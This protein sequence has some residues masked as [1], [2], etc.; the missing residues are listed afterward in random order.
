MNVLHVTTDLSETDTLRR[1]FNTIDPDLRLECAATVG[2][3]IERL[4]SGTNH[5]DAVLLEL[6]QTNGE[7][8]SLV[9]HIREH[10]FPLGVVAVTS[11]RDEAP[12]REILESGVDHIVVKGK[13]FLP[14]LSIFLARAVADRTLEARLRV[15]LET[16][17]VCLMRVAGDGTILA[18]NIAAL[19]MVEAER[20]EQVVDESWYERVVPDAQAA[21]RDLIERASTGER[22]SLECQIKRLSGTERTVLIGAVR[23]PMDANGAPS[24][25]VV[26]RD[27]DKTRDLET[28]LEQS[29][30]ELGALEGA[31]KAAE[32]KSEQLSADHEAARADWEAQLTA[33]KAQ[34]AAVEELHAEREKLETAL[35]AAET[36][37]QQ[38]SADHEAERSGWREQLAV[39]KAQR[40]AA[41]EEL[42]AEREKLETALKAAQAQAQELAA[43]HEAERT[44]W[45]KQRTAEQAQEEEAAEMLSAERARLEGAL[46]KAKTERQQLTDALASER[47][48]REQFEAGGHSLESVASFMRDVGVDLETVV[49]K[50]ATRSAEVL[51][52]LPTQDP[53]SPDGVSGADAG[54]GAKG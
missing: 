23:A 14:R 49:S 25:L 21:C 51:D 39:G 31:L 15:M 17:P 42:S 11:V 24:A 50:I 38:L 48:L 46:K 5:H 29:R 45:Q 34:D 2:E 33:G 54:K 30:R 43:E 47:E 20:A 4:E 10:H 16:A 3:A 53:R 36:Q 18:M 41:V 22:G 26:L 52:S 32:A 12:S 13:D 27:L 6:S 40:K 19:D 35:K 37:S 28:G 44:D 8:L 1:E 9:S 7:A